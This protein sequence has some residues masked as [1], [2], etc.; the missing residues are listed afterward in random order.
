MPEIFQERRVLEQLP[1]VLERY[2]PWPKHRRDRE[3]LLLRLDRG[4][5]HPEQWKNGR[6]DHA[7][8]HDGGRQRF[9]DAAPRHV[10][11]LPRPTRLKYRTMKVSSTSS[12]PMA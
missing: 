7:P 12:M 1:V 4:E 10:C 8:G 6:E 9:R 11:S 5:H 3:Q 2:A